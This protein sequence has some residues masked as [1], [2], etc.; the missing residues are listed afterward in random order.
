MRE[1]IFAIPGAFS[2]PTIYNYLQ[3]CLG[4]EY[5]WES[6]DYSNDTANVQDIISRVKPGKGAYHVVGHS[7]GGLIALSLSTQPWVK[8][9][10]TISAPLGGLDVNPM[11]RWFSRSE[12]LGEIRSGGQFVLDLQHTEPKVPTQHLVSVK[13]FNPYV[14][15]PCDG[16]V[17]IRSQMAY[18]LGK[19]HQVESN[20]SEIMLS[21][22]TVDLLR[23]FW[24]K[25]E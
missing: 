3:L 23:N 21:D 16:V 8:S 6:I 11:Q 10:T 14:Y 7:L 1:K 13:G 5:A 18:S 15:E 12:F 2:T 17:S 9:V 24:N 20:H 22:H 25:K 4:R 19:V